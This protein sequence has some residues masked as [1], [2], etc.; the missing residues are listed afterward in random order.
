LN[1]QSI[2][3]IVLA[4]AFVLVGI[5][6]PATTSAAPPQGSYIY[7]HVW[8]ETNSKGITGVTVE[9]WRD[10][11][12]VGTSVTVSGNGDFG[13][14]VSGQPGTYTV[15]LVQPLPAGFALQAVEYQGVRDTA[16]PDSVTARYAGRMPRSIGP[17]NFM[18]SADYITPAPHTGP[19]WWSYVHGQVLRPDLHLQGLTL[20][21]NWATVWVILGYWDED[22]QAYRPLM[23]TM[24]DGSQ[25]LVYTFADAQGYFGM[26]ISFR[27]W[28]YIAIFVPRDLTAPNPGFQELSGRPWYEWPHVEFTLSGVDTH[29]PTVDIADWRY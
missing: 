4:V 17:V 5:I 20:R 29:L 6:L 18:C 16:T 12:K 25:Q 22:A 28:R 9:L 13:F 24:P 14:G 2:V 27:A 7:G 10:G 1:K 15:K 3:R 19:Y 26:G 21:D 8:D 23:R 11:N